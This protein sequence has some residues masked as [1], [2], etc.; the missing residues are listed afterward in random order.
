MTQIHV[1]QLRVQDVVDV[2]SNVQ[3]LA[4]LDKSV[5]EAIGEQL[6]VIHRA[7]Y[8]Q[9]IDPDGNPWVP[10][11]EKYLASKK[12]KGAYQ[13]IL[14]YTG[15]MLDTLTH[16]ANDYGVKFGSNAIQ[17]A[18]QHYGRDGIPSRKFIGINDADRVIIA[19]EIRDAY[20]IWL[21][22]NS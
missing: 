4:F 21:A 12:E 3:S 22:K 5:F 11:S 8:K 9:E 6:Q 20:E 17:A 13:D 18:S 10:L 16:Q 15:K 7:R 14:Q 1:A 19:D 2:L